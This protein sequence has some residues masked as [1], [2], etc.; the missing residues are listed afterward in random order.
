MRILEP[1]RHQFLL[2]QKEG[3]KT[4]TSTGLP[5]HQQM[6]QTEPKR[7]PTNSPGH[8]PTTRVHAV[9]QGRR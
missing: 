2:R 1:L 7:V 4:Q 3:R 5:T 9:H 6:D 8:R